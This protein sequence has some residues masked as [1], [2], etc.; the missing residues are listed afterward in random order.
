LR[1]A[2]IWRKTGLVLAAVSG[3]ASA[4]GS[5]PVLD[6]LLEETAAT[7]GFVPPVPD[8]VDWA[9]T[10]FARLIQGDRSET[11]TQGFAALG[12]ELQELGPSP[13]LL[14]VR[15]AVG[16]RE[17]KGTYVLRRD[18]LQHVVVL[19]APHR[20]HDRGTG[21]I[22]ARLFEDAN[23]AALAWNDVPRRY[24]E[25]GRA[26]EAD[27]ARLDV[28]HLT[29]FS[30]AVVRIHPEARV[31]QLHGFEP[32]KRKSDAGSEASIILSDGTTA[33]GPI[34]RAVATCL[35][36]GFPDERVLLYPDDVSE[37]GGTTNRQGAAMRAAGSTGFLH[38]EMSSGLRALL[39]S[40]PE[41]RATLAACLLAGASR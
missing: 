1:E 25:R 6:R 12:F 33:P 30:R 31:V 17:G 11:V 5:A 9:E 8:E 27:L 39:Q 24:K 15:E 37:L 41:A 32:G 7:G 22:A 29:G 23:F 19:Q 2:S 10:L 3:L 18:F 20:F 40:T 36:A 34:V 26:V 16:R 13:A 38:L 28:H 21:V 35:R 14:V 4:H